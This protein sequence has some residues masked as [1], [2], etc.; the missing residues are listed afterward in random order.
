M[1]GWGV[2]GV[3]LGAAAP[4]APWVDG[5]RADSEDLTWHGSRGSRGH[6]SRGSRGHGTRGSIPR[7]GLARTLTWRRGCGAS[8]VWCMIGVLEQ[9]VPVPESMQLGYPHFEYS[10]RW[11][12][13]RL[14]ATSYTLVG[15]LNKMA[16]VA[17]NAAIWCPLASCPSGTR[18]PSR[19]WA[20][21]ATYT[22]RAPRRMGCILPLPPWPASGSTGLNGTGPKFA[23]AQH[24]PSLCCQPSRG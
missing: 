4:G 6:G 1:S 5:G 11:C 18:T 17:A 12:R 19:P 16:S 23:W 22:L 8:V 3:S 24:G 20:L 7:G 15:F 10:L 9:V 2:Q 21:W 13:S 14:S